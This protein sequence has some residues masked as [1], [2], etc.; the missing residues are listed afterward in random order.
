MGKQVVKRQVLL[1]DMYGV[2]I[3][4][5]KGY[6]VPYTLQHFEKQEHERL[7]KAF[8]EEKLF[9][10]AQLGEVS[11]QEFLKY[12]GYV[13]PRKTME[14]YLINYL[15]L[16][17]QFKSFAEKYSGAM[18]FCLL[19]NDVSEWSEFLTELHGLNPYFTEKIVSGDVGM[20]KPGKE[21]FLYTLDKLGCKPEEGIFVDNSVKN[22]L[23]AEEL[24]MRTILFNRDGEEYG[25]RVVNDFGELGNMLENM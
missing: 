12:L 7:I 5:S 23:V 10:K 20:R 11:N 8:R 13:E 3:K 19:S 24:G 6:F 9:T 21:I 1:L 16:D 22:L 18:D 25:G 15:T 2:I 17:E 14:D 4:E